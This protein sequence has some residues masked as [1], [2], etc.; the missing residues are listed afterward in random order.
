MNCR[1]SSQI[2]YNIPSP[3]VIVFVVMLLLLGPV[4][5]PACTTLSNRGFGSLKPSNSSLHPLSKNLLNGDEEEE[6]SVAMGTIVELR[7]ETTTTTVRARTYT[8]LT[9]E[10]KI[11]ESVDI[12]ETNIVLQGLP[13]DIYNLVNHNEDAKQI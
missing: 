11:R 1:W 3:F 4:G 6:K 7:N 12:K 13:Q 10:E 2:G 5:V 9:D 8:D